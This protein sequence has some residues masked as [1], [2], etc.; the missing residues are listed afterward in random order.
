MHSA[1][2]IPHAANMATSTWRKSDDSILED[3]DIHLRRG[4]YAEPVPTVRRLG[5][6]RLE[7]DK[8]V[9]FEDLD[10]LTRLSD[11]DILGRQRM[12]G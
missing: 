12:N 7:R 1:N 9:V 11:S 3:E 10:F 5:R 2:P 4:G 6:Q 8:V